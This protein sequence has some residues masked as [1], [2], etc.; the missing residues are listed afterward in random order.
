[1]AVR[2]VAD[3]VISLLATLQE[4]RLILID[5]QLLKVVHVQALAN[6]PI[7]HSCKLRGNEIWVHAQDC[8][9]LASEDC[10]LW[11][12]Y[13]KLRILEKSLFPRSRD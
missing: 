3:L 2:N 7:F 10:L 6:L 12:D 9:L 11:R 1:M 4:E 8:I 13:R 5:K